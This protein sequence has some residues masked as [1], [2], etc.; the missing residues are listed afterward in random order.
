MNV[1]VEMKNGTTISGN[2]TS[3][4]SNYLY[5]ETSDPLFI[6][7]ALNAPDFDYVSFDDEGK[8][9]IQLTYENISKVKIAQ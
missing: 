4:S 1:F 3:R 5:V 7:R 8:A 6:E 2:A 9:R